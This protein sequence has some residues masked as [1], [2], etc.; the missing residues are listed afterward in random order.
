[1]TRWIP[2]IEDAAL[3]FGTGVTLVSMLLVVAVSG[4][5]RFRL[6]R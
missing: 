2:D 1:M 5:G 6:A 4:G 3:L